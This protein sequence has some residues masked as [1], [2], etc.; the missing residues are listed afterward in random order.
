[1]SI[2]VLRR[3]A[4]PCLASFVL[5]MLACEKTDTTKAVSKPTVPAEGR[6]SVAAPAAGRFVLMPTGRFAYSGVHDGATAIEGVLVLQ[7]GR[8]KEACGS[9]TL[10]RVD[11]LRTSDGSP[12]PAPYLGPQVGSG[13]LY[14]VAETPLILATT[15]IADG[16]VHLTMSGRD[17]RG[18]PGEWRYVS[19]GIDVRGSFVARRLQ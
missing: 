17:D 3:C 13:T 12:S 9:W 1:M 4:V 14:V 7:G 18:F 19:S 11:D 6:I 2:R 16:Q 15:R 8:I 10:K 5:C